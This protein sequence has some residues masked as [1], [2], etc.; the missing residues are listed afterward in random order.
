[1]TFEKSKIKI[2]PKLFCLHAA[3]IKL[4]AA[5]CLI[6][7]EPRVQILSLL[8][9]K[10]KIMKKIEKL[11]CF[12]IDARIRFSSGGIISASLFEAL[13]NSSFSH[14][15]VKKFLRTPTIRAVWK[16]PDNESTEVMIRL[17]TGTIVYRGSTSSKSTA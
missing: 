8:V 6:L 7:S 2:L 11:R 16:M 14:F 17:F 13:R 9:K 1:M 3:W 15:Y 12:S 4:A 10:T 5:F